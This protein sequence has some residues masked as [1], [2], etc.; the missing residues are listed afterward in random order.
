MTVST[1]IMLEHT[2]SSSRDGV[3]SVD[4]VRANSEGCDGV[5]WVGVNCDCVEGGCGQ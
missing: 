4:S 5:E 1:L 3:E 2:L